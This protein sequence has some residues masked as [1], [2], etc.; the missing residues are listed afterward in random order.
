MMRIF[1]LKYNF[2]FLQYLCFILFFKSV[3][4][5]YIGMDVIINQFVRDNGIRR[6]LYVFVIDGRIKD[7]FK[8]ND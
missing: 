7:I 2:M 1:V 8:M 6:S 3:I 5:D 4:V